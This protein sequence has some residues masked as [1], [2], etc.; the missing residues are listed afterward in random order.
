MTFYQFVHGELHKR[1][2]KC[3]ETKTLWVYSFNRSL[4]GP[5]EV[6]FPK[7][8]ENRKFDSFAYGCA[9]KHLARMFG[10]KFPEEALGLLIQAYDKEEANYHAPFENTKTR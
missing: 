9:I 5:D 7:Q 3:R 1:A 2:I 4:Y 6:R 8:V 10:A